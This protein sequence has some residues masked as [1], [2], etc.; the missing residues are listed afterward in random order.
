[1][2]NS[3]GISYSGPLSIDTFKALLKS[4]TDQA[5]DQQAQQQQQGMYGPTQQPASKPAGPYQHQHADPLSLPVRQVLQQ[6]LATSV[7]R[8]EK[9]YAAAVVDLMLELGAYAQPGARMLSALPA[10]LDSSMYFVTAS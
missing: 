10:L 8:P 4:Y 2:C 5:A 6:L 1:M 7:V 3:D 9:G